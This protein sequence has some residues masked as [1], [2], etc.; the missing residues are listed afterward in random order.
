MHHKRTPQKLIFQSF[1]YSAIRPLTFKSLSARYRHGTTNIS[2]LIFFSR[3]ILSCRS[4][5]RIRLFL[6]AQLTDRRIHPLTKKQPYRSN[7]LRA[8]T[9][10]LPYASLVWGGGGKKLKKKKNSPK[11][12]F[13]CSLHT[14]YSLWHVF[15]LQLQYEDFH[16]YAGTSIVFRIKAD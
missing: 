4:L 9:I 16:P 12:T 3:I 5:R 10:P 13:F 14:T 11:I 6:S 1:V 7:H 8:N 15:M 2:D